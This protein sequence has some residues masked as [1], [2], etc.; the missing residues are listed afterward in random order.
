[1][2]VKIVDLK[3]PKLNE[4]GKNEYDWTYACKTKS[5]L[6][7]ILFFDQLRKIFVQVLVSLCNV[8]AQ[9]EDGDAAD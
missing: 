1:M 7:G 4:R 9:D 2:K 8:D 5:S 6:G 3:E